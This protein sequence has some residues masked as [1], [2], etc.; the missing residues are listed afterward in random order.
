[1]SKADLK[2]PFDISS[3]EKEMLINLRKEKA[4][5]E[6]SP[7]ACS[8]IDDQMK[9]AL[10]NCIYGLATD[11][12]AEGVREGRMPKDIEHWCYEAVMEL[13]DDDIFAKMKEMGIVRM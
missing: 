8:D 10:F 3:E 12:F 1:M 4:K 6:W 7:K 11:S 9:I 13:L 5:K 2:S